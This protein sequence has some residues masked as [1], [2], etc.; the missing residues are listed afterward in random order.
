M[1]RHLREA[2][3]DAAAAR[4]SV[5]R[6]GRTASS[7]GNGRCCIVTLRSSAGRRASAQAAIRA[8]ERGRAAGLANCAR[9]RFARSAPGSCAHRLV[10]EL[11]IPYFIAGHALTYERDRGGGSQA[12]ALC[13]R[14]AGTLRLVHKRGFTVCTGITV[15]NGACASQPCAASLLTR[16]AAAS[17]SSSSEAIGLQLHRLP[18]AAETSVTTVCCRAT[19]SAPAASQ[20]CSPRHRHSQPW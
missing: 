12:R 18:P 7:T 14:F 1:A 4:A 19:C 20:L 13:R 17:S 15:D 16:L 9:P 8:R 11:V 5:L 3:V 10:R 6:A 2:A